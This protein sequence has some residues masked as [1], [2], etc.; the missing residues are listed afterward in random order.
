MTIKVDDDRIVDVKFKTFGC[1]AAVAT[2]SIATELVMGKTLAEAAQIS[3]RAVAEALGGLPAAEDALLQPRCRRAPPGDR[4]LSRRSRREDEVESIVGE[5]PPSTLMGGVVVGVERRRRQRRRGAAPAGGR[6]ATCAP[7]RSSS[8]R[9]TTNAAAVLP[10]RCAA[11]ARSPHCL[12]CL[13]TSSCEREAFRSRGR[14]AL[15]R[16]LSRR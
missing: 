3:N 9:Q 16:R 15:R 13:T 1:G 6:A 4:R 10:R 11:P 8:G 5:V 2:S 14:R 12:G 7:R